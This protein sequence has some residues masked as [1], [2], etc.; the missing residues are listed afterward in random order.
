[1]KTTL[2]MVLVLVAV[3]GFALEPVA[4]VIEN[5][6]KLNNTP[7]EVIAYNAHYASA[8]EEGQ[9]VDGIRHLVTY[10]NVSGKV[11]VAVRIGFVS[12]DYFNEFIGTVKGLGE[13]L[14]IPNSTNAPDFTSDLGSGSWLQTFERADFAFHTGV[15]Y[16][17]AVRFGDGT[18]W[19]A[20]PS[21]V[22]L[23]LSKI[24]K[25]FD[26]ALLEE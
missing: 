11:I 6:G 23:E 9:P 19:K 2:C 25:A 7:L 4:I 16:V 15:A 12:F 22:A 18:I 13:D 17:S 1:M 26:A 10:K 14:L 5:P 24:Q 21:I 20:D 8:G 3:S